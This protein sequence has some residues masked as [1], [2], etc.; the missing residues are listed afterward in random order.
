MNEVNFRPL[1][2][3]NAVKIESLIKGQDMVGFSVGEINDIEQF[4]A[5]KF[6]WN[7]LLQ[8]C[9]DNNVFLTWEWLFHWWRYYGR[10]K[11]LRIIVIKK[12]SKI[13]GIAPFMENKYR[14]GP[15]SVNVMENLC[16]EECDYS[17]IILAEEKQA[18]LTLLM[19]YLAVIIKNENLVLRMYHIPENS[20]FLTLLREQY[21]SLSKSL[22]LDEQPSSYCSY[23][24]LP[25]TWDEYFQTLG[26]NSRRNLTRNLKH[27]QKEHVVEFKKYTNISDLM[28]KLQVLFD[29]HQK[30]WATKNISSKFASQEAREFYIDVSKAFHNNN[31]LNFSY[32]RVDEKPVSLL[33]SFSYNDVFYAMTIATDPDYL[34]YSIGNVLLM[35]SVENSIQIGLKKFDFLKGDE[36]YK[37]HWTND[38][39]NNVKITITPNSIA[40]RYRVILLGTIIKIRNARGRSFKNNINLIL[41]KLRPQEQVKDD[42]NSVGQTVNKN[43]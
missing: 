34:D 4:Q 30:K 26:R 11:K 17:G 27:I 22:Y 6:Q 21:P 1:F 7:E 33:W 5:L 40:G 16:S 18:A 12:G 2:D 15:V 9:S 20:T 36:G 13:V 31:W 41:N 43:D 14:Q 29:L 24:L 38:K 8:Q 19:D 32:L 39:T 28:D 35:K 23:I 25:A 37:G 42:K 3:S 10:N